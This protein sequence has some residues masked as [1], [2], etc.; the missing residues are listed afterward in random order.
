MSEH[1]VEHS[2]E[3][4]PPGLRGLVKRGLR[5]LGF[6]LI[7]H[8][9]RQSLQWQLQ[10]L[11]AKLGINC[12]LDVGANYG[13]YA[14]MLR[15]LGFA[16][17]IISFEPIPT[18]FEALRRSMGADPRWRGYNLALGDAD[19]T[20]AIN[21]SGGDAQASSLLAFNEEGPAR[22]GDAHRVVRTETIQIR[23]LDGLLDEV[24]RHVR[25]PRIFLKLDTQGYDLKVVAGAGAQLERVLALQ[26]EIS[27]H[28]YYSGMPAFGQAIDRYHQLGFGVAGF[29][30]ISREFDG[31]RVI[32]FD[33]V[34]V[35]APRS[36]SS[37]PDAPPS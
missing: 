7:R 35:R 34:F 3:K 21:V 32:E 30:P 25:E 8:P 13:Q 5:T 28:H 16:G 6:D 9:S 23:R 1:D 14:H 27:V 24:T 15:S 20:A 18:V 36:G 29:F 12:V 10:L 26:T 33:T 22:W 17:D 4:V 11:F 31:L 2:F 19:G 37:G